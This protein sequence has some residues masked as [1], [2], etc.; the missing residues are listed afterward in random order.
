[1]R[2]P[3]AARARE[4][5]GIDPE[6]VYLIGQSA[7]GHMVSLAATLGAGQYPNTGGWENARSDVR[8]VVNVSGAY[9]LPSL[10]AKR[11]FALDGMIA[12]Y[13]RQLE[14]LKGDLLAVFTSARP[15][16]DSETAEL[17]RVLKS[18]LSREPRLET[19]VDPDLLGGLVIKLGSRMIDSSIRTKLNGIRA[20]MKGQ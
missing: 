17:K 13:T 10:S 5:Y 20:A 1:M 18:G 6:R 9:D 19:R 8:A 12:A 16:S 2:H 7:G 4:D 14:K 15:L 11:L 3:L